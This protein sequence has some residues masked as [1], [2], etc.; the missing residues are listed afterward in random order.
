MKETFVPIGILLCAYIAYLS[1]S[2]I[3]APTKSN[4]IYNTVGQRTINISEPLDIGGTT[5]EVVVI[6]SCE[7]LS[8]KLSNYAGMITHKGN[9]TNPVH[10]CQR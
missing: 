4:D 10:Q 8:Y 1:I 7:Y 9:C 2:K 5:F 6:D 3:L